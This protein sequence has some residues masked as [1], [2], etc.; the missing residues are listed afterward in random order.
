MDMPKDPIMLMSFLNTQ[1]RDNYSS[2][3][4]LAKT[5][6]VSEEELVGKM[7]SIGYK[8]DEEN[9]KFLKKQYY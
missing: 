2:L 9:N 6:G 1:L 3:T 8:Y 7:E 5:Y 4:E